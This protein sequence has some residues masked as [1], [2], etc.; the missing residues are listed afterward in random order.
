MAVTVNINTTGA[1]NLTEITDAESKVNWAAFGGGGAGLTDEGDFVI[2]G[3]QSVSKQITGV[4]TLKGHWYEWVVA[5]GTA[6]DF[7]IGG[8]QEGDHVF[9]WIYCTTPTLI[10]T[11][12]AGGLRI[13]LGS[14]TTNWV[15]WYMN[16]SDTYAEGGWIKYVIDPRKPPS[17]S[18]GTFDISA[19]S[20]FGAALLTTGTVKT[21]NLAIDS[22][23]YG[24]GY[25]VEGTSTTDDLFGDIVADDI[26]TNQYGIV[27]EDNGI[28]FV[29]GHIQLGDNTDTTGVASTLTDKD[30]V[31]VFENPFYYNGTEVVSSVHEDLIGISCVGNDNA[32]TSIIL[33]TKVGSGDTAVGSNGL[34]I[35]SSNQDIAAFFDASGLEIDSTDVLQIYGT[36]FSTLLGGVILGDDTGH[37]FIGTVVDKCGVFNTIGKTVIRNVTV[38]GHIPR[39]DL[40]EFAKQDD[41]TVFTDYANEA[42]QDEIDNVL[43]FPATEVAAEDNFYIGMAFRFDQIIF[44]ISTAGVGGTVDWEYWDGSTWT[45]LSGGNSA[46]FELTSSGV[47]TLTY[48]TPTDWETTAIDG[49]T[50]FWIRAN[51]TATY[52]TNPLVARIWTTPLP[53]AML[54]N[55][56]ID[57]KNTNFNANT[58][59]TLDIA[60][61]RHNDD[62]GTAV[63]YDNLKFSGND[64]DV[65]AD[66]DGESNDFTVTTGTDKVNVTGHPYVTDDRVTLITTVTLPLGLDATTG[67]Y[68][69]NETAND[70][71]LSLTASPGAA[72]DIQDTGTGTHTVRKAL[73][74][75]TTNTADPGSE[76][77]SKDGDVLIIN[78]VNITVTV[79]DQAGD[80]VETAQVYIEDSNSTILMNEDTNASGVATES[81]NYAGD[82]SIIVRIRKS[83]TGDT[84]YFPINTTGLIESTG[85][86]LAV[87]FIADPIVT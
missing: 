66:D 28:V 77:N 7:S 68:V 48:T 36:T 3:T 72:V 5:G 10:D 79:K 67:Y 54:W 15:E 87:T 40:V 75:N 69:I 61:I 64:T 41:N 60:A 65:L 82:E 39:K 31:V 8:A 22:I 85:F 59:T 58:D 45:A 32:I 21:Q 12:A 83:S 1:P 52:S 16:G 30:K 14:S 47:Q 80:P 34:L 27:R 2:E 38:S 86:S 29:R 11:L 50:K 44:N 37:D 76:R 23:H 33:G 51:L 17:N 71:E 62:N 25:Q 55:D 18:S 13:R 73:I 56:N 81:Y 46:T 4:G 26:G 74:V 57:I 6:L 9:M 19:V 63:T 42:N 43:I 84:K 78:A 53:G 35:Q 20:H 24:T 49:E 70:F